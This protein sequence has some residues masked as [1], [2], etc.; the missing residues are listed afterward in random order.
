MSSHLYG[1][2]IFWLA[3]RLQHSSHY[4]YCVGGAGSGPGVV[5]TGTGIVTGGVGPLRSGGGGGRTVPVG[6]IELGAEA[7]LG[8]EAGG[9]G[10]LF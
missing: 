1:N 6:G 7:G 10:G 3:S 9:T 5:P 2:G 8:T 4:A